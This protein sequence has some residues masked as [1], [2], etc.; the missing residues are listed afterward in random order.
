MQ[1]QLAASFVAVRP[2]RFRFAYALFQVQNVT[3]DV[4][5]SLVYEGQF[6]RDQINDSLPRQIVS[7]QGK[8]KDWIVDSDLAHQ[9][10]WQ[11][12]ITGPDDGGGN[13]Q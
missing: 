4:C 6:A 11:T 9:R 13:A 1:R 2:D 8:R 12:F 5:K 10:E 7:A 3:L